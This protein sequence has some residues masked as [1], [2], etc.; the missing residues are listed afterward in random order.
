MEEQG[1]MQANNETHRKQIFM[2]IYFKENK[3][4]TINIFRKNLFSF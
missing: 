2:F 1:R 3:F 4:A